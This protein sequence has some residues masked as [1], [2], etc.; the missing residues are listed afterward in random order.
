VLAGMMTIAAGCKGK[1]EAEKKGQAEGGHEPKA[2]VRRSAET[3]KEAVVNFWKAIEENDKG[4][5]MANVNVADK[6]KQLA[7]KMF[8]GMVAMRS[9]MTK[10]EKEYGKD[11]IA[12]AGKRG[13]PAQTFSYKDIEAK[14]QIK[15]EADKATATMPEAGGEFVPPIVKKDG[16]WK[17]DL[18]QDVPT[19]Q[20]REMAVKMFDR[21]RTAAKNAEKKIGKEGQTAEK[22]MSE[23]VSE[24]MGVDM[25]K[26]M[27]DMGDAMK[28]GMEEGSKNAPK[29]E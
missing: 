28:K 21:M 27:Q 3:P 16:H 17:V 1:P 11:E 22:I 6:D 9:V 14:V 24:V 13:G 4:L 5:F 23:M 12:K 29:S 26:M 18:T 7:E 15:E 8:D 19:D 20:E 10:L 2:T 25:Q